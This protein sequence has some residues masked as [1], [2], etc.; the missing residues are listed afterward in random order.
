MKKFREHTAESFDLSE[1]QCDSSP[2]LSA[3]SMAFLLHIAS[4]RGREG[5]EFVEFAPQEGCPSII[6]VHYSRF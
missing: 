6:H 2:S 5:W 1:L 4:I 3:D